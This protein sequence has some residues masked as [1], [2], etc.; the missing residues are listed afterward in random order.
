MNW[1]EVLSWKVRKD[2]IAEVIGTNDYE[3]ILLFVQHLTDSKAE[4]FLPGS[5]GAKGFLLG[6]YSIERS[7]R[8]NEEIPGIVTYLGDAVSCYVDVVSPAIFKSGFYLPTRLPLD[9]LKLAHPE[10]FRDFANG[11]LT[12]KSSKLSWKIHPIIVNTEEEFHAKATPGSV[13]MNLSKLTEIPYLIVGS[14]SRAIYWTGKKGLLDNEWSE[15]A[16]DWIESLAEVPFLDPA[17]FPLEKI[18]DNFREWY[19]QGTE[20]L[21]HGK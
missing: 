20:G 13:W 21:K 7:I 19:K 15:E 9:H 10:R 3:K 6:S 2:P 11:L 14:N 5:L 4:V 17:W 18:S 8:T 12:G 16:F 1:K